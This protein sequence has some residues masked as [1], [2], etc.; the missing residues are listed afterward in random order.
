MKKMW[1]QYAFAHVVNAVKI[2]TPFDHDFT[3]G[4]QRFQAQFV[5]LPVPPT[6]ALTSINVF[7]IGGANGARFAHMLDKFEVSM[8]F[9]G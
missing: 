2:L 7:K 5:R 4:E 8:G 9:G 1:R 6:I 3:R